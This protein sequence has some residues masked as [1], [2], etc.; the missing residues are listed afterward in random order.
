MMNNVKICPNCGKQIKETAKFCP[1]CGDEVKVKAEPETF[2]SAEYIIARDAEASKKRAK[3]KK[4]T[5][6]IV[7]SAIIA[8][9]CVLAFLLYIGPKFFGIQLL[10]IDPFGVMEEE[11]KTEIVDA[12]LVDVK[13]E[14]KV[15]EEEK[16]VSITLV[17]GELGEVE[18]FSEGGSLA[19]EYSINVGDAILL[20]ASIN[21]SEM[22]SRAETEWAIVNQEV[23]YF[24][25][26]SPFQ[27]TFVASAQGT[28]TV[29]FKAY[30][31][32]NSQSDAL[33]GS[34]VFIVADA[35]PED[36]IGP[37]IGDIFVTS[38][39]KSGIFIRSEPIV[40]GVANKLND[41]NK[42]GWIE[43]GDTTIRLVA[44][45]NEYHEGGDRHWWYEVEI[46][47]WYRETERQT[48]NYKGKP[49]V[50]WV[51]DDVVKQVR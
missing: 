16:I 19:H 36:T 4:A 45:G 26:A 40:D 34:F 1:Y 38:E 31:D 10:P 39:S 44:T 2:P 7:I 48:E 11:K 3:Q 5:N 23:G 41:G 22:Q 32:I 42:I 24:D 37:V 51:R 50:G 43:G 28:T 8:A 49:L 30:T 15:V 46:P 12:H 21:P 17:V 20:N 47:E 35:N 14:E 9:V 6:I 27:A 33:V 13:E 29:E 25:S 18:F